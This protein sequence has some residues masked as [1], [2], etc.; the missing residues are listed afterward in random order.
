MNATLLIGFFVVEDTLLEDIEDML[1]KT[2]YFEQ[3]I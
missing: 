2:W 1:E 3:W